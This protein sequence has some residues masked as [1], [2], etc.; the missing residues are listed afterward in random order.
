[1]QGPTAAPRNPSTYSL[2]PSFSPALCT[3][4]EGWHPSASTFA[5]RV[6]KNVGTASPVC[7]TLALPP[8]QV[9]LLPGPG[10]VGAI[11]AWTSPISGS[12]NVSGAYT[13]RNTVDCGDHVDW[14]IDLGAT[15]LA[16][17]SLITVGGTQSFSLN[18]VA[19][20]TGSVLYFIVAPRSNEHCDETQLDVVISGMPTAVTLRSLAATHALDDAHA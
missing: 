2:L 8:G 13:R 5:P 15:N 18:S 17:G 9:S 11:V 10:G 6:V 19:V 14:F 3:G 12:V 1:M 7:D 16:S 20:T 4:V